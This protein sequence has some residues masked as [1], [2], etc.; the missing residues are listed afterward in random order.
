MSESRTTQPVAE[1]LPSLYWD[2]ARVI[3][4]VCGHRHVRPASIAPAVG[5]RFP[6]YACDDKLPPWSDPDV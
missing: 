5:E 2:N 1:V 6:C 3:V 4:L